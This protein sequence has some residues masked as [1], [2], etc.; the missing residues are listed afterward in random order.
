M[1]S[2]E[3][4][5]VMG[6]NVR[7]AYLASRAAVPPMRAAGGGAIVH[8]TSVQGTATQARVTAYTSSKGALLAL[9]RAMAVL[10]HAPGG[11]RVNSVSPGCIDAPM[12]HFAASENAEPGRERELIQTW[13]SA[14]PFGR[15]G[16]PQKV[17]ELIAFLASERASFCAGAD[18]RVDAGLLAKLGVVR[19]EN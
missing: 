12:T 11:I 10:D 13:G 1:P 16:T 8:I 9:V 5:E 14:Q 18:Y 19:P 17:A 4:D 7:S 6:V 15:V 3:W 2:D